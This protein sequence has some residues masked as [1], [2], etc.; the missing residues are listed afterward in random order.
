MHHRVSRNVPVSRGF[1]CSLFVVGLSLI[2]CARLA[3]QTQPP[4][5]LN[6]A[7]SFVRNLPIGAARGQILAGSGR[8]NAEALLMRVFDQGLSP[9]ASLEDWADLHLALSG[10]IDLYVA[11]ATPTDLYHASTFA[12]FDDA[13]YR[14][15]EGN[16][17]AALVAAQASLELVER[18]G[19]TE[20]LFENWAS[21]ARDL[22]SLGRFQEAV[23][24]LEKARDMVPPSLTY[25]RNAAGV[26]RELVDAHIA[27][28][29]LSG[30][31]EEL[32]RFEQMTLPAPPYF[33]AEAQLASADLKMAQGNY[34]D[35]PEIVNAA[36]QSVPDPEEKK[37][38]GDEAVVALLNC[39]LAAENQL[40]YA[41]ALAL[42]AKM[43]KEVEGLRISVSAFA[44]QAVRTRRR[45]AGDFAATLRED[46]EIVETA[47]AG[48]Q[49]RSEIEGLRNLA[50]DYEAVNS[51]S[52]QIAVL[53]NAERFERALLPA[54]G[55]PQGYPETFSWAFTLMDLSI[56]YTRV[57]PFGPVERDKANRLLLEAVAA[58]DKQPAAADR[59]RLAS[60]RAELQLE[61]AS[62][63]ALANQH[64][65]AQKLLTAAL[66]DPGRD[67]GDVYLRMARLDR[68]VA[69]ERAASSYDLAI[70]DLA[71]HR[72][73]LRLT[74]V[75]VEAAR[76][77]ALHGQA[78]RA[79]KL[80]DQ[81]SKS[82]GT[83]GFADTEWKLAYIT[84]MVLQSQGQPKQAAESYLDAAAKLEA[85]RSGVDQDQRQAFT[86]SEWIADM[87]GRLIAVLASQGR[88]Q[89]SWQAAERAKAR[90][91]LDSL[92]GR[93]FKEDVPAQFQSEL[94]NLEKQMMELRVRLAPDSSVARRAAIHR[95]RS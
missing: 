20:T 91:F 49:V 82:A 9:A 54:A 22:G 23:T 62:V 40:P 14:G 57:K 75:R 15:H 50:A 85:L 6:A 21:I 8:A 48:G 63:F 38:I 45:L 35:I 89:D 17:A 78:D 53:E 33:R 19:L 4:P 84:G 28:K 44:R 10:L 52:N 71:A 12:G 64:E 24:A 94:A 41:E 90:A 68:D 39:V 3:A 59:G 18:S 42:A 25:S 11:Q 95:R 56:A 72:Q 13:A 79:G 66:K 29:D 69:P 34:G 26:W 88:T 92:Q 32:K 2:P 77:A 16:Y 76:V 93:R 87:Y 55:V 37:R 7:R 36:V 83:E 60:V 1:R 61:R 70:D 51:V 31:S 86:D 47:R 46:S 81:A 27:M 67:Q 74:A 80:L 58:V 73:S 43:D 65:E 30:A 5:D